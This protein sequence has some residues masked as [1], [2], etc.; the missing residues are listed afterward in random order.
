MNSFRN[1]R[2]GSQRVWNG[3]GF[4]AL[5][6]GTLLKQRRK[7]DRQ[8]TVDAARNLLKNKAA[9]RTRTH[10]FDLESRFAREAGAKQEKLRWSSG[11][12]E[13]LYFVIAGYGQYSLLYWT[14][15]SCSR[16]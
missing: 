12:P 5:D 3:V 14:L 8:P 15:P 4:E 16:R 1:D 2:N 9:K 13:P 7:S 11:S 10:G 6:F